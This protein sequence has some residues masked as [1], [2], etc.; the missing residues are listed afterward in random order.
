[1]FTM[2]TIWRHYLTKIKHKEIEI[3]L[4]FET[5]IFM[6]L[7]SVGVSYIPFAFL[8]EALYF[9]KNYLKPTL[10][11]IIEK[12]IFRLSNASYGMKLTTERLK[13][14]SYPLYSM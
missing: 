7:I 5:R 1:M 4:K 13:I 9:F 11:V 3:D 12:C 14:R 8:F 6:F 10:C 2:K